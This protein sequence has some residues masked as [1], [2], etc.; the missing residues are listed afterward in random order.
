MA[1]PVEVMQALETW[2]GALGGE[3]ISVVKGTLF[4]SDSPEVKLWPDKFG[5]A[6]VRGTPPGKIEQA[7]AA[8][9]EKRGR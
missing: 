9:G 8:P 2:H 3:V 4:Y 7:T 5:P 6:V 1:K